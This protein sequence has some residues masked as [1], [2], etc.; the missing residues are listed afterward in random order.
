MPDQPVYV[1]SIDFGPGTLTFRLWF[2]W[3]V[4][5]GR[6]VQVPTPEKDNQEAGRG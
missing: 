6:S 3:Q 5:L 1:S 2:A 4:I